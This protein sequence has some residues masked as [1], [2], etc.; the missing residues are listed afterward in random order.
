MGTV[1]ATHTLLLGEKD[2]TINF[3]TA[4]AGRWDVCLTWMADHSVRMELD[5]EAS[6]DMNFRDPNVKADEYSAITDKLLPL[7]E[8]AE[9]EIDYLSQRQDRFE[10]T[11]KST[12]FRVVF[13]TI[14]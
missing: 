14:I 10:K 4:M 12:Y 3:N 9:Y 6:V 5:I 13:F 2:H 8:K 7:F 11:T 1:V